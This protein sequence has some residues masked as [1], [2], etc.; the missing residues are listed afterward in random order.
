MARKKKEPTKLLSVPARVKAKPP[1]LPVKSVS[2][3]SDSLTLPDW[4]TNPQKLQKRGLRGYHEKLL[5]WF[6]PLLAPATMK[7]LLDLIAEGDLTA[8]RMSLEMMTYL[9]Q[10]GAITINNNIINNQVNAA[11]NNA[12]FSFEAIARQAQD[13]QQAQIVDVTPER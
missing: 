7:S 5:M 1:E 13:R 3:L 2:R 10:K 12:P 9:G 8:V 11:A 6:T 4:M